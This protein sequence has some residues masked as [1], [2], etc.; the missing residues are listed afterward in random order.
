MA[1]NAF[2]VQGPDR[3]VVVDGMLTVTDAALV[4]QASDEAFLLDSW[5]IRGE[6]SCLVRW[7]LLKEALEPASAA[8]WL[9]DG[10][11]TPRGQA[12]AVKGS[13]RDSAALHVLVGLRPSLDR[14]GPVARGKALV[15][16][17]IAIVWTG[18]RR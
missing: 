12:R 7:A 18:P 6:A 9:L 1:V 15:G 2:L 14:P 11:M 17:A 10:G 16:E 4:R 5:V 8:G 13:L 3:V